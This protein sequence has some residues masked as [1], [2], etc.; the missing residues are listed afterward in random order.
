MNV[1]FKTIL[2]VFVQILN[3]GRQSIAAVCS[4]GCTMKVSSM[5]PVIVK[6]VPETCE[7]L[8]DFRII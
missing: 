7:M 8:R 4:A 2:C 6:P 5:H 1:R 3:Y